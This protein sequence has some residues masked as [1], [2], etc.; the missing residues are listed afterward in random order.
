MGGQRIEKDDHT[1]VVTY[2]LWCKTRNWKRF[3]L[4]TSKMTK[5]YWVT[6]SKDTWSH[7]GSQPKSH[8]SW[9]DF[10]QL[11]SWNTCMIHSDL[12]L[13]L[14]QTFFQN[15]FHPPSSCLCSLS[16]RW[17]C[18]C[19]HCCCCYYCCCCY[20]C[21]YYCSENWQLIWLLELSAL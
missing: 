6:F 12:C 19:W 18:W 4:S 3:K 8:S 15:F 9:N 21:C 14:F 11:F 13:C 16:S 2:K 17:T 20:C 10:W 1:N 7:L 5:Y